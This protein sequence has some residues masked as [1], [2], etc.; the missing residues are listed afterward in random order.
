VG[1]LVIGPTI[2][3]HGTPAQQARYQPGIRS[4]Q[5]VYCLGFSEPGHGSDL[6]SI[7][8][9]G[10][11]AGAEIVIT[12]RKAWVLGAER[13]TA[14]LVLCRTNLDVPGHLGLSCVLVGL[15]RDNGVDCRPV[16]EMTGAA[17]LAEVVLDG[18]RAPLGAVIGGVDKGWAPAMTALAHLRSAGAETVHLGLEV[19]LWDLVREAERSGRAQEPKVRAELAW[20]YPGIA[21]LRLTALRRAARARA[22]AQPGPE[23]AI[24][25]V[26]GAEHHRRF[27]EIA[28]EIMGAAG[29]VRPDGPGYPTSRWQE[30]FL[31]SRAAT[32]RSGTSEV[33]RNL[34]AERI[35]G[36]PEEE[37]GGL[38]SLLR[39]VRA[40]I[41]GGRPASAPVQ[42]P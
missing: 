12:G 25:N 34:I 39:G 23:A 30:V 9:S 11:V 38:L 4:G 42:G 21:V 36:L 6:A 15:D 3:V 28:L 35:L 41:G 13:A 18:A 22:G 10:R 32:I 5:D 29:M 16:R 33:L 20:A 1:E 7:E 26:L 14:M 37:P 19:E 40:R 31:S 24:V 27:G 8:T 2:R 17:H